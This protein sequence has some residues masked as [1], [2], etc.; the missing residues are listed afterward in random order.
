MATFKEDYSFGTQ[1]EV[2]AHK[3]IEDFLETPLIHKGGMA[4]FDFSNA[5]GTVHADLKTRRIS[6]DKFP[7]AIIGSNKVEFAQNHPDSEYWFIYNY[8]DGLYGVQYDKD[9]FSTFEQTSYQR[10]ER[11]DYFGGSQSCHFIPHKHLQK[12]I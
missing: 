9:L 1:S 10:G 4:I 3:R 2:K 6:H 12:I 7:T 8:L 11:S 5:N